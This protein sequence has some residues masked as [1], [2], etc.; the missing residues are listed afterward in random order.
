MADIAKRSGRGVSRRGILKGLGAGG[1][2]VV[3]WQAFD[4]KP[5]VRALV[6]T[7]PSSVETVVP[8]PHPFDHATLQWALRTGPLLTCKLP[9]GTAVGGAIIPPLCIRDIISVG[10]VDV[11]GP[12]DVISIVESDSLDSAVRSLLGALRGPVQP[13]VRPIGTPFVYD[14]AISPPGVPAGKSVFVHWTAITDTDVTPEQ[15]AEDLRKYHAFI[16]GET[17]PVAPGVDW[18]VQALKYLQIKRVRLVP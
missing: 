13:E 8:P 10:L 6:T 5:A 4:N 1:A 2:A 7:D 9:A 15:L 11:V 16:V 3:L 18:F 12:Y 17:A 14:G